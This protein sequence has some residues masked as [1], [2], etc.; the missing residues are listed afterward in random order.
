MAAEQE[1]ELDEQDQNDDHFQE[2]GAALIELL[3]HTVIE[4]LGGAELMGDEILV[5]WNAGFAGSEL[6][7]ASGVHVAQELDGVVSVLGEPPRRW[8][9]ES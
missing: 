6:V 1:E 2:K 5:I 3:D 8:P 9:R 4:F 7:K